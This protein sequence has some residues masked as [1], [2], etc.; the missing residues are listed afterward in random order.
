MRMKRGNSTMA[1]TV[2]DKLRALQDVLSRKFEVEREIQEIPKSLATK[3]E[4]LNRVKKSSMDKGAG[5]Q[6]A[7]TQIQDFTQK[8]ADAEQARE[9]YEGQM[10]LIKTQREYEALDKEIKE[11]TEKE[12]TL[13]KELQREQSLSEELK[14][15]IEKEEMMI[16]KQEE[17]VKEEQSK[18]KL[19]IKEKN[20]E[21]KKLQNEEKKITPGLDEEILFKFERIIKSKAGVGIVSLS[22]GVCAG[23]YMILPPQFVNTVRLGEKVEFCP[24]CSRILFYSDEEEIESLET[25]SL[26][27]EVED[28]E[29]EEEEQEEEASDEEEEEI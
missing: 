23:C 19:K 20:Q 3:T 28:E 29:E 14:A 24:Y 15:A 4:L 26:E 8:L 13:R 22:K 21:L 2:Y 12:Q 27:E 1:R 17:D 10:D 6:V 5:Y 9:K 16:K 11:A 18:I 7:L 25:A